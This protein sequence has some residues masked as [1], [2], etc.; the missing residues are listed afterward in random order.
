MGL[1]DPVKVYAGTSNV[2]AQMIYRLLQSAGVEAFAGEDISP[3]G[4]WMGGTIPG[5]FDAGVY[6]SRADAEQAIAL[7]RQ[8]E[9]LEAER[10]SAQ[11]TEVETTCEECGKTAIY[12]AAQRGTVQNCPNCGAY[13]DVGS[14]D[15]STGW[16]AEGEDEG[17]GNPPP[18]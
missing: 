1:M 4:I 13:L 18:E 7:I 11:G 10:G 15:P 6:V 3:A 17:N 16:G 8:H 2:E 12:L 5:V 14:G 9:R